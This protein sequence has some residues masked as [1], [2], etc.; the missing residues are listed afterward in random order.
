MMEKHCKHLSGR[1][2]GVLFV[3][4][5]F[6]MSVLFQGCGGS[7]GG[8]NSNGLVSDAPSAD[9]SSSD[10]SSND[11]PSG[12]FPIGKW[13]SSD[14][15]SFTITQQLDV[16]NQVLTYYGGTVKYPGGSIVVDESNLNYYIVSGES[17][18]GQSI[19]IGVASEDYYLVSGNF[20]TTGN[21]LSEVSGY[22]EY[23]KGAAGMKTIYTTFIRQ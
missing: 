12:S 16:P 21:D 7:S 3:A 10:D 20:T 15:F 5:L 1:F 9:N 18:S 13:V 2:Y 4:L 11:N 14:G 19:I 23:G 17:A 8:N 22:L 6:G